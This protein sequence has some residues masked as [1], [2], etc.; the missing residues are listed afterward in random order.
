MGSKDTHKYLRK[1]DKY[2]KICVPEKVYA[3][4]ES[5]FLELNI[6]VDQKEKSFVTSLDKRVTVRKSIREHLGVGEGDSVSVKFSELENAERTERLFKDNKVDLLSLNPKETSKGYEIVVSKF[7]KDSEEFLRIW[8][9]GGTKGARQI[10][11]NRF[12]GKRIFGEILGQYQAEGQKSKRI[13]RV[14]FTNKEIREHRDFI[15]V[16]E[17]LGIDSKE[18]TIQ[19]AYNEER[20]SKEGILPECRRFENIIGYPVDDINAYGSR[21]YFVFRT[22]VRS[23]LFTEIVLYSMD[24]VRHALSTEINS[25]NRVIGEGYLAKL[26]TGDGTLDTTISPSRNYGSPS[27]NIK[28]VD[29]DCSSLEDYKL[30]LSDFGFKP[31]ICEENMYVRS[32]CSLKNLLFLYSI[33][34]FKNTR[35]RDQLAITVMLLLEGRRYSTYERLVDLSDAEEIHSRVVSERYGVSKR[36]ASE[37]LN[38]KVEEGFLSIQ[39][40][41]PY[42]KLYDLTDEARKFTENLLK[43]KNVAESIKEEKEVK[44]YEGALRVLKDNIRR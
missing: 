25:Q 23:V 27:I 16:L 29:K 31:H 39:R 7:E 30:I 32:S 17:A 33:G 19:C 1:L 6:E 37:W 28:I 13:S 35:N 42:P 12:V 5:E 8:S 36:A 34:A 41:S 14:T 15:R 2:N 18:I 11:L 4:I 9:S 38:N 40:E 24:Y 43:V 26:L 3:G 22:R 20:I 21:G 44:S 10:T